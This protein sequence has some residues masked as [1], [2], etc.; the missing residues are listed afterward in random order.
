MITQF[1][2]LLN[3]QF[4][5]NPSHKKMVTSFTDRKFPIYIDSLRKLPL[6]VALSDL[7]RYSKGSFLIVLPSE[8][9]AEMFFSDMQ[10]CYADTF[11]LPA[12]NTLPYRGERPG[13]K[14]YGERVK[15]L[16]AMLLN[17]RCVTVTSAGAFLAPVV[18][19]AVVKDHTLHLKKGDDVNVEKLEIHM[20]EAGYLRVPK[21]S[22]AGDFALRGEVFDFFPFG[23]DEAV[24]VV[25]DFDEIGEIKFFDPV[26]QAST[27]KLKEI[28]VP[29][30][31]EI[32][33]DKKS[34][35]ALA[36][37]GYVSGDAVEELRECGEIPGEEYLLPLMFDETGSLTDYL[38]SDSTV[39]YLDYE[40]LKGRY[41]TIT[42]E[43]KALFRQMGH[44]EGLKSLMPDRLLRDF[45]SAVASWDRNIFLPVLLGGNDTNC[46]V[47]YNYESG[48]SFFGNF[49]YLKEEL[50]Q[51]LDNGYKVYIFSSS[52]TQ[53]ARIGKILEELDVK[54]VTGVIS[55]GFVLPESKIIAIQENEIFGRKKRTPASV[56]KVK[57][58]PI[59]SFVE[60]NKGDFVVHVNYGIG[61][62]MGIDRVK[63]AGTERDYIQLEYA[64]EDT[65]FIPIE[66][67]NL[68][69]RY[70]GSEG[71]AP[72]L[73]RLGS[74][75]W[76]ARKARAK[77]AAE[78]L[79]QRLIKLYSRRKNAEGYPFPADSDMQL[80]FEAAFPY[81]ET[82]DQLRCI[83]EV[84][85]DMEKPVPMDRLV[86]GDVGFGKTEIAMR[87]VFKAVSG[88]KQAALLCPTTIL[89]EQHFESFK[90]RFKNFPVEIRLLSRFVPRNKQKIAIE[91][92]K[93]GKADIL[94]GTH[95]IL[96]KDV[97]FKNLGLM[98]VDEE[99]RFGVKDKERLKELKTSI[100]CLALSATPI[101][102]TLHMSLLKIRDLSILETPP[103]NRRPIETFVQPFSEEIV[104]KA[105]L[106][107]I[108]RGGQVFYLH[109]RVETLEEVHMYLQRMFPELTMETAHGK[110]SGA[111]LE[112]IMDR[113]IHHG[114]HVL[115]S[116]TIVE[117]GI[118]IPNV[119][120][121]II[122]RADMYGIS[123]LYQL[124]GR[125]GR[126]DKLAYAY[127]L[128]P[129]QTAI[130][131]IAMKR[132]RIIS[133][134]TGLGAGFKVAMKDLEVRGAGNLL[135]RDQS[136][137][138]SSV[139]FDMYLRLID[140]AVR[141]LDPVKKND[142]NIHEVYLE[143]EYSGYIPDSYIKD[144]T[145]KM[146]VY[147]K[148]SAV[149][150]EDELNNIYGELEDRF[151]PVPDEVESL[152]SLAEIRVLCSKLFITSMRER[153]GVIEATFSRLS[154]VSSTK[155]VRLMQEG[156]GKISMSPASPNVIRIKTNI[157]DLK[158]K[159]AFL[160]DKLMQLV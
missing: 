19:P 106:Q 100:D 159:S 156:G 123:Q 60:L 87:A 117:N 3:A 46:T 84:K 17:R 42:E 32:I 65:I 119:N 31:R 61:K 105:I 69:Q 28:T 78:E 91:D 152:I 59:D 27:G 67:V 39:V 12:W 18:P 151:G 52:E 77:K 76:E 40:L 116:T 49:V 24:R 64:D 147:K 36:E 8:K 101:P 109:N 121:I 58:R 62:F 73:D 80:E 85:E 145:E 1:L 11:Y 26:T 47:R 5:N 70:I 93:S 157:V 38:A 107:E 53:A 154:K 88:G 108:E 155:V 132:L 94:I 37:S 143:L 29:P 148:I 112:D 7:M 158:E 126:S 74:K 86:C 75:S 54:V 9:E 160:R 124:R 72:H 35:D 33:W 111:E 97:A 99:Q 137:E 81:D 141:D 98:V 20:Q 153:H 149:V 120:T 133:D 130:S 129:E 30:C 14:V 63:S 118:D 125:V 134:N 6:A 68:I 41:S 51:L 57:S 16:S 45:D 113:F 135:G 15:T 50:N 104:R 25:L 115:I 89:A 122:D 102:R 4:R 131:E 66:Q 96:Q 144:Q 22:V 82:E 95:R 140:E 23:S 55:G 13:I 139:G 34:I 2:S 142:M 128:Y 79:A 136:G 71:A 48:R 146:E 138:I 103:R 21:V 114:T 127:L 56:R 92:I 44:V 150:S 43:N 83:S 90:E 110:M 10:L